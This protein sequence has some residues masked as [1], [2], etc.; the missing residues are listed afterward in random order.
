MKITTMEERAQRSVKAGFN[1]EI[2]QGLDDAIQGLFNQPYQVT[3]LS[4]RW[5]PAKRK[6]VI[7]ARRIRKVVP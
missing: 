1:S 3:G 5:L 7:D 6:F 4:I 2:A